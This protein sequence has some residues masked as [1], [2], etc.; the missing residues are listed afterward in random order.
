MPASFVSHIRAGVDAAAADP[1]SLLVFSGGQT[2]ATAGPRS[3]ALS[4]WMVAEH[5]GWWG[6]A[7]AARP[8]S[9]VEDYARDSFENLMFSICRFKEVVGRYPSRFTVIGYGFKE[10]RFVDLH[11][12]ALG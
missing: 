12:P 5:F 3:E 1:R 7:E 2:R 6:G 10:R 4:Y 8:R 11:R 9:V